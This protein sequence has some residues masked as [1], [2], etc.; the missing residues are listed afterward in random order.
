V[1]C[2]EGELASQW[3]LLLSGA[4]AVTSGGRPAGTVTPGE[5]FGLTGPDNYPFLLA[6]TA[7]TLTD[8]RVL[9]FDREEY[10]ALGWIRPQS[11]L[12]IAAPVASDA[13]P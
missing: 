12:R 5:W 3:F 13:C 6:A 7:T 4:I 11:E 9:V 2:R 10:T 1:L 8:A